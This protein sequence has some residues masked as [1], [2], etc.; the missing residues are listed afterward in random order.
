M[1]RHIYNVLWYPA[2]PLALALS[3]AAGDAAAR[4]ARLGVAWAGDSAAASGEPRIWAHAASVGEVGALRA[5]IAGMLDERPAATLVVTTMTAAGRDAAQ[6]TI[7]NARAC[8]LAPLDCR[9]ALRPFLNALRPTLVLITETELWP[10]YFV[11]SRNAGARVAI[12][13][14]RISERALG[15]Y[16]YI[17]PLLCEALVCAELILVQTDDDARRFLAL[18]APAGRLKVTGN[19]KFD[20]AS[21]AAAPLRLELE[22]FAPQCA[23]LVAGSTAPSEEQIVIDAWRELRG[24][25]DKL[26]LA[27]A[28]RHLERI[29]EVEGILR[30]AK[31]EYL[32]ASVLRAGAGAAP[33][34]LLLD[35][36][37]ELRAMYGRAAIA[38]VGGSLLPGRG[39]QSLAEPAAAGVPV[40]FGPFHE[41]QR[42]IASALLEAR[43]GSVVRD[44]AEL[45]RAAASFLGDEAQR[46]AAGHRARAVVERMAGGVGATLMHL[47]PLISVA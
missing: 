6:R 25:F 36:M 11:E 8:L 17:R 37:G 9:R 20:L 21:L 33:R 44:A 29:A 18:G 3:G 13:N 45:A 4:R 24:R 2:L 38:F 14:G 41:S 47:R 34:V 1:L 16:R 19:T 23:L 5:V 42:A 15:R 32:K 40:L 43:A 22:A 26:A 28:P 30:A 35:T 31:L 27:L 12:V 46:H 7:P 39:G 10:N